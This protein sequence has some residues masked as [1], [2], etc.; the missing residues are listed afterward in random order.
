MFV[1]LEL[2]NIYIYI[3]IY[4]YWP[5]A[6]RRTSN[7]MSGSRRP[8]WFW[9]AGFVSFAVR[10]GCC[11]PRRLAVLAVGLDKLCSQDR[12]VVTPFGGQA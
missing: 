8:L 5:A 4:I 6:R 10:K 9:P 2:H 1:I 12:D 7:Q 11:G 3:Y